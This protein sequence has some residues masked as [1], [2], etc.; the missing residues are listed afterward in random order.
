MGDDDFRH[1]HHHHHDPEVEASPPRGAGRKRKGKRD[2]QAMRKAPHA[3]K[4]FK[5]SYI[6][7]FMAKQGEIKEALG[8]DANVSSISKRSAEMWYVSCHVCVC[9]TSQGLAS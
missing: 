1:H 5:S 8:E 7:F 4:R 2:P 3:P 6:C 9:V